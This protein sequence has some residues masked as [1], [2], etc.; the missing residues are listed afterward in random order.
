M[1]MIIYEVGELLSNSYD[2]YWQYIFFLLIVQYF[3]IDRTIEF[4]IVV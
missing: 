2:I 4:E 3:S 1:K